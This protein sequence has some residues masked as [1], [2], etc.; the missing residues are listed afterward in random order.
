MFIIVSIAGLSNDAYLLFIG[1]WV[2]VG[3]W[4]LRLTVGHGGFGLGDVTTNRSCRESTVMWCNVEMT[5][6]TPPLVCDSGLWKG[7]GSQ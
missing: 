1:C 7:G 5:L 3:A 4:G 2:A 6:I